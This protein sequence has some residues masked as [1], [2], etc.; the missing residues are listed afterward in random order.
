MSFW[1][2]GDVRAGHVTGLHFLTLVAVHPC[3]VV[4]QGTDYHHGAEPILSEVH[5]DL[6]QLRQRFLLNSSQHHRTNGM[7]SDS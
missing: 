6:S 2:Y 3:L 7:G 1:P 4:P 5:D